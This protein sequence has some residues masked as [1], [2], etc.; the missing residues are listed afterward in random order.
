MAKRLKI[1]RLTNFLFKGL[2]MEAAT[3]LMKEIFFGHYHHSLILELINWFYKMHKKEMRNFTTTAMI[4]FTVKFSATLS[5]ESRKKNDSRT[6]CHVQFNFRISME[7]CQR[8]RMK[9]MT[10][11]RTSKMYP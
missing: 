4:P 3:F 6:S 10:V 9:S 1:P 11:K 7:F 8:T 5:N 2:F